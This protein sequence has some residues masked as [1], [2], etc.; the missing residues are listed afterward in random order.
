[1]SSTEFCFRGSNEA[2][3]FCCFFVFQATGAGRDITM[4]LDFGRNDQYALALLG[5]NGSDDQYEGS[6]NG[7]NSLANRPYS[8]NT[9]GVR[10]SFLRVVAGC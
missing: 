9:S 3:V 10:L 1:M 2:G 8:K 4:A 5:G 7:S 6:A